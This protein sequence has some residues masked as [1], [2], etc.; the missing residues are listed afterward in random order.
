MFILTVN[1]GGALG[2]IPLVVLRHL[3]KELGKP[4]NKI[5]HFMAGVSTGSIITSTLAKGY[6]ASFVSE[7]YRKLIPDIFGQP[8]PIWKIWKPKYDADKLEN[9]C[10]S[11]LN[12]NMNT[13]NI[14]LMMSAVNISKPTICPK[15]WKSWKD[16]IQLYDPVVASCSAPTYF[17]PH[18]IGD[19]YYIDGGIS[20]NNI[21]TCALV[22][23]LKMGNRLEDITIVNFTC[24]K[25]FGYDNAEKLQGIY[26]WAPKIAS[27]FLDTSNPLVE[28]QCRQLI[29]FKYISLSPDFNAGLDCTDILKM[30]EVGSR[31]WE[32]NKHLLVTTL[33][34]G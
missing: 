28:Y 19:N 23:A 21:S 8:N 3:E 9:I 13:L 17:K 16:D 2:L 33:G 25:S 10:K 32:Q 30:E 34:K 18:R 24:Y 15:F 22:E 12:V 4:L 11:L 6:E 7:Q 5:F 14:P 31:L 27:T 1:G 29:G 20:S 26:H